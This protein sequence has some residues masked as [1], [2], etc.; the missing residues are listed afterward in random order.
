M[1]MNPFGPLLAAALALA[2]EP[3]GPPRPPAP[4]SADAV[5]ALQESLA[6]EGIGLDLEHGWVSLPAQVLDR[7]VL[8]EYLL[9]G[10]QGARHES[11][12][13]TDVTPSLVNTALLALGLEPGRN[14]AW[15][16]KDTGAVAPDVPNAETAQNQPPDYDLVLPAGDGLYLY[17]GWRDGDEVFLYRVEDLL[18]DLAT[19]RSMRRSKWTYLGSRFAKVR[20]KEQEVFVAD[21]ED[22]LINLALFFQGNTLLTASLPECIEQ[23]IWVGN[24]WLLPPRDAPIELFLSRERIDSLPAD[25]ARLLPSLPPEAQNAPPVPASADG[26]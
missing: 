4:G 9:V 17:A 22:D 3:Q 5:K 14:A 19:G 18:T 25:W 8:L 13:A 2:Q 11:L 20:D 6:R 23:T 7:D 26:K 24:S 1:L 10:P 21:L 16:V 15:V 12:F